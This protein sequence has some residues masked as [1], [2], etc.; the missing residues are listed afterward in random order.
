MHEF[1][2]NPTRTGTYKYRNLPPP[3][4][5]LIEDARGLIVDKRSWSP[6]FEA[7]YRIRPGGDESGAGGNGKF[8]MHV[9]KPSGV[10]DTYGN[11][12]DPG[13]RM[14][15]QGARILLAPNEW[16]HNADG[17][18]RAGYTYGM[19]YGCGSGEGYG[20]GW[21]YGCGGDGRALDDPECKMKFACDPSISHEA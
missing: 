9:R 12:I 6:T 1:V 7:R 8:D 16:G 5:N 18:E 3:R 4:K 2:D 17:A 21:G 10:I 19:G 11:I 13:L 15:G 20:K 14:I